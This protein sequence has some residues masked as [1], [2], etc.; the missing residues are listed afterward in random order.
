MTTK[1]KKPDTQTQAARTMGPI[2]PGIDAAY[3]LVRNDLAGRLERG[4]LRETLNQVLLGTTPLDKAVSKLVADASDL[5]DRALAAERNVTEREARLDAKVEA[6]L[7]ASL[8]KD[9]PRRTR[10]ARQGEYLLRG[11][12]K[13]PRGG[14]AVAGLV[15]ELVDRDQNVIEVDVTDSKGRYQIALKPDDLAS[16]GDEPPEVA[17][18]IAA[19]RAARTL[20]R[21]EATSLEL[22]KVTSLD[23]TLPE[24]SAGMADY[25]ELAG[26]GLGLAHLGATREASAVREIEHRNLELVG[27][28]LKA[29][30][31][32]AAQVLTSLSENES[33]EEDR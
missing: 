13:D 3:R 23:V 21:S 8:R 4:E 7:I 33:E 19:R 31:A 28:G 15:V 29:T 11:V 17:V 12:V 2:G 24:E 10:R 32:Q 26:A 5:V 18:R 27:S 14:K 30:L 6:E 9:R 25:V 20:H 16:A 1:K 22:G